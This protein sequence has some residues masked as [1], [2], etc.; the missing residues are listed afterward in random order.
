MTKIWWCTFGVYFDQYFDYHCVTMLT[1]GGIP[2]SGTFCLVCFDWPISAYSEIGADSGTLEQ[3]SGT[4]SNQNKPNK[5]F[6]ILVSHPV[7]RGALELEIGFK[8]QSESQLEL[9][10]WDTLGLES[11]ISRIKHHALEVT[12]SHCRLNIKVWI[13]SDPFRSP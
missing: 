13:A 11:E 10:F 9:E 12:L 6:R 8:V 7:L 5:R 4:W 2:K 1:L 3:I